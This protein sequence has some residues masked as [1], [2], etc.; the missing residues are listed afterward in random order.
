M[1]KGYTYTDKYGSFRLENPENTSF[2][3]FPLADKAMFQLLSYDDYL[4]EKTYL[5]GII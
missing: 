1:K 4:E 2:L 5:P 3:Y